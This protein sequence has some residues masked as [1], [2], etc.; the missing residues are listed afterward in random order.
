MYRKYHSRLATVEERKNIRNATRLVGFTV[1]VMIALFFWGIPALGR[2]TGFVSDIAKGDKPI[3]RN[4][5]TP[6]APPNIEIPQRYT[7][8]KSITLTGTSE[9][10]AIIKITLNGKESEIATDTDGK[11]QKE[12]GLIK[13]ENVISAKAIDEAGNSSL[14]SEKFSIIFDNESPQITIDSPTEGSQFYGDKEKNIQVKGLTEPGSQVYINSRFVAVDLDGNFSFDVTLG[15][16]ENNFNIKSTDQA[17]N[18]TEM[19]LKV[20]F[21]P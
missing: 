20:N 6:P 5:K 10:G 13:G 16:G 8:Q 4:D 17:G 14:E 1:V 7:N 15:E 3:V 11:F 12:I 9:V 2:L 21:T 18:L 19:D